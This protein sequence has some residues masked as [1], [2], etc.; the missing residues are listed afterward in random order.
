MCK[1]ACKADLL[2]FSELRAAGIP[3]DDEV[4]HELIA[5]GLGLLIYQVTPGRIFA[6]DGGGTG[7]MVGVGVRNDSYRITSP[8]AFRLEIPWEEERFAWLEPSSLRT[9]PRKVYRWPGRDSGG[10]PACEVLNHRLGAKGKLFPGDCLEGYLLGAG[11]AAIPRTYCDGQF[12]I[13]KLSIFDGRGDQYEAELRLRVTRTDSV[14]QPRVE[15]QSR[16]GGSIS[17]KSG[18]RHSH[19]VR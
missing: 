6:L 1:S 8:H 10:L 17:E 15:R 19:E 2:V 7:Y 14:A 5:S 11:D 16:F 9:P 3:L 13:T 4:G 12:A 18:S